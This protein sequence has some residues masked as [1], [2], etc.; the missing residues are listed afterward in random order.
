MLG[1]C[2][3]SGHDYIW[4]PS[5]YKIL[6]K[7]KERLFAIH[8]HDNMGQNDDHLAPGEGR[9]NWDIVRAGIENT[10]YPGSYTLEID[11]AKTLTSRT[12]QEHLMLCFKSA[13]SVLL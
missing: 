6:E 7:Y 11:T 9:I 12:P 8:L 5:P 3:D 1:L 13:V 4:S 2:Y 10:V